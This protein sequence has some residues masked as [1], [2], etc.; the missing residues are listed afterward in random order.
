MINIT[1]NRLNLLDFCIRLQKKDKF[2]VY[3]KKPKKYYT[4]TN[5]ILAIFNI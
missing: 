5:K 3:F 2:V 1:V 4:I